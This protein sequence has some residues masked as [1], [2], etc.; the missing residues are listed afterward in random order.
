MISLVVGG[1]IA[2]VIS[3]GI[4]TL[5]NTAGEY[6]AYPDTQE[7]Q[8]WRRK[9]WMYHVDT[10][11][12]KLNYIDLLAG[13][14]INAVRAKSAEAKGS[15]W[16]LARIN[17]WRGGDHNAIEIKRELKRYGIIIV[18]HGYD[19]DR[20]YLFVRQTQVAHALYRLEHLHA[21]GPSWKEQAGG[22]VKQPAAVQATNKPRGK[23]K[24]RGKSKPAATK[25]RSSNLLT[26][27]KNG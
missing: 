2:A 6:D 18:G 21:G 27:I 4:E 26:R 19:G 13:I 1:M 7:M 23:T 25:S 10:V 11:A 16:R 14:I 3:M 5:L 15:R 12:G 8:E 24:P 20:V 9:K 17:C 22:A